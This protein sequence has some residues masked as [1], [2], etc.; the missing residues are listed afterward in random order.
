[1]GGRTLRLAD[2]TFV[3]KRGGTGTDW[4]IHGVFDLGRVG[5]SHL[6]LTDQRGA[7]ALERGAPRPDEIRIGDRNYARASVLRRFRAQS[8]GTPDFIVR[9]GWNALQ[10]TNPAGRPFD[11]LISPKSPY[12]ESGPERAL[13][14][15]DRLHGLR[16]SCLRY[17][18]AAGAEAQGRVAEDHEP[19]THP[20]PLTIDAP[21]G[22]RPLLII[23]GTDYPTPD[24]TCVRDYVHVED[25]ASAHLCALDRMERGSLTYNVGVGHGYSVREIISTVEPVAGRPVPTVAGERRMGDPAV[26]VAGSD[27]LRS[28]NGWSPRYMALEDIVSA[29]FRWRETN[30]GGVWRSNDCGTG[31]QL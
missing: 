23:F 30:F 10:L 7:E 9:L 24:G 1:L 14:W 16:S 19:E 4:R 31:F 8:G 25:L 2:G 5:F 20:I 17:F 13:L 26:L 27:L 3:S 29:A 6:E 21:L 28:E 22:R 18:N 12:G 11:P 15:A